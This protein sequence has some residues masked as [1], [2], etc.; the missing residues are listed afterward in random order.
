MPVKQRRIKAALID[1]DGTLYD[2]MPS[3]A[4]AWMRLMT[5]KGIEADEK[6]FFLYEGMTGAAIIDKMIM[7]SLGRHATDAEK[8]DFY[9]IKAR[10]FSEMAPVEPLEGAR[11]MVTALLERDITTVLVTGSGQASL[12]SR[13]EKDFPGAFPA[14]RRVT[15]ASVSRGKPFPEPYLKGLEIAGCPAT[16]AIGI[17]NAPLG[18]QSSS[19]AGLLTVGVVTGPIPAD[20]LADNGADIV[21]FSMPACTKML[22]RLLD[23]IEGIAAE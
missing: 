20:A 23:K 7:R 15:S 12:L 17:D 14:G 6:E 22:P 11:E 16:R 18:T 5:E 4:R 9:D 8:K 1:M 2:S 13:L 3:H 19:A 10:Y 21:F